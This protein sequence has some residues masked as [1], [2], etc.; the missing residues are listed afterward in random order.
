M[1]VFDLVI[2]GA[3]IHGLTMLKTHCDVRPSAS[4]LVIEKG[5]SL[6][7]VRAKER[8]HTMIT[9]SGEHVNGYIHD[10]ARTFDLLK[11]MRSN[12]SV[13]LA[14]D[15]GPLGWTLTVAD[16][17]SGEESE[18]LIKTAELIVATR[19][20][21]EP[22]LPKLEG[23]DSFDA[24]IYHTIELAKT[25]NELGSFKKV[26]LLS[27]AKF[28]WDIACG[29]GPCWI[30]PPRLTP[31]EI[32]PE[33]LLQTRLITWLS[34]DD[35]FFYI[36]DFL[37]A[38]DAL[39]LHI[40]EESN[41]YHEH[42]E[43][44]ILHP[45]DDVFFIGTNRGLPNYDMDFFEF[46]RNG[47]VRVHNADI[48]KLSHQTAHLSNNDTLKTD[49]PICGT[50][51]K[52][53][54]QIGS[55]TER[56]LGLPGHLSSSAEPYIAKTDSAVFEACPRLQN[57]PPSRKTMPTTED[58]EETTPEPSRLYRFMIPPAFIDSRTLA[59]S[60]AYRS[61]ATTFIAQTKALW[62]TAFFDNTNKFGAR[63]PELWVD[64]LPNFDL[65]LKDVCVPNEQ[66]KSWWAERYIAYVP[67]DYIGMVN[68]YLT[69]DTRLRVSHYKD[70]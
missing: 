56:L 3:G 23:R 1:A 70:D 68:E 49:I 48:A 16:R 58:T 63:F 60:G 35:W 69:L 66:N 50:G 22:L 6:G 20:T 39:R 14:V 10:L 40:I 46:V 41:R 65:F 34:P 55:H 67:V 54:T 12:S 45:S 15:C 24:T 44:P 13:E 64:C 42:S 52:D 26:V 21:S 17:S 37:S 51:W 36:R 2:V 27:G 32:I 19:L 62:I 30:T 59:F 8:L 43:T 4:N 33:L 29:L 9:I 11:H 61:L 5:S 7:G 53:T 18:T 31:F 25:E 38:K 28:S 47:T 57:Q